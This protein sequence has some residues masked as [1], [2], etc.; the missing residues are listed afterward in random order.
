MQG[1]WSAADEATVGH[2]LQILTSTIEQERRYDH[3]Y[4]FGPN[5]VVCNCLKFVH[6]VDDTKGW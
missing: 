3:M 5:V 2:F 4:N 1:G 6:Q